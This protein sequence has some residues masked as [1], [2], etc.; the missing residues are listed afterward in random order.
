M[1]KTMWRGN[2]GSPVNNVDVFLE[3]F[4]QFLK[5]CSANNVKKGLRDGKMESGRLRSR[6]DRRVSVSPGLP[7]VG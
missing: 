4:E 1:T 3:D 6:G 5:G 2:V 7:K